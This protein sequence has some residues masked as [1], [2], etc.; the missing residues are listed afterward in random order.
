MKTNLILNSVLT[1]TH[2]T[3][4][5]SSSKHPPAFPY[6]SSMSH[7]SSIKSHIRLNISTQSLQPSV[8]AT[9][10]LPRS[11]VDCS[12][13]NR[14]SPRTGCSTHHSTTTSLPVCRVQPSGKCYPCMTSTSCCQVLVY[15]AT[16]VFIH[17][18]LS[19]SISLST[20]MLLFTDC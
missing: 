18:C 11:I 13:R 2:S 16:F 19:L 7:I 8:Y 6:V 14:L 1:W 5:A 4:V 17:F 12:I 15:G 10:I 9:C 20:S 3:H